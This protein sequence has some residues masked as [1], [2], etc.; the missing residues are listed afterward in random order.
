MWSTRSEITD[1]Y[2]FLYLDWVPSMAVDRQPDSVSLCLINPN[3]K[4][5]FTYVT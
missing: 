2:F 4:I 1:F 5:A 3:S